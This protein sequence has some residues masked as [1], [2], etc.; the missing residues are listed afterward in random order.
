MHFGPY[1]SNIH[2]RSLFHSGLAKKTSELILSRFAI[3]LSFF[4]YLIGNPSGSG[5]PSPSQVAFNHYPVRTSDTRKP[6]GA[7]ALSSPPYCAVFQLLKP[8]YRF[9]LWPLSSFVTQP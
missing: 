2:L 3:S 8:Q 7:R 5:A 4:P 6:F 1:L 9:S